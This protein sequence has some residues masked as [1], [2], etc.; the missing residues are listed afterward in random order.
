MGLDKKYRGQAVST[1]K[2]IAK[3]VLKKYVVK[4]DATY[5]GIPISEYD[6]GT[7]ELLKIIDMYAGLIE[8]KD[9]VIAAHI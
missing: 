7:E 4:H 5:R 2:E 3:V 9:A 6:F 1:H 8:S